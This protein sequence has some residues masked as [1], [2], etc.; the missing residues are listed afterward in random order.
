MKKSKSFGF[1][2]S[3][4]ICLFLSAP[5]FASTYDGTFDPNQLSTW[6]WKVLIAFNEI[7][8]FLVEAKNPKNE[9]PLE[10]TFLVE[11]TFDD[12]LKVKKKII[13]YSLNPDDDVVYVLDK[14]KDRYVK[15]NMEDDLLPEE[16]VPEDVETYT[17]PGK[18]V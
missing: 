7:S 16:C 1:L 14:K 8:H 13:L 12:A 11:V 2:V 17:D 5:A 3:S 9:E 10:V 15:K 6:E 4:V 18:K